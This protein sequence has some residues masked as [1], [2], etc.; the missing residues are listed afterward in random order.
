MTRCP[1]LIALRF[2]FMTAAFLFTFAP[3]SS[4]AWAGVSPYLAE[5]WQHIPAAATPSG[6]LYDR[7]LALSDIA[8]YDGQRGAPAIVREEWRQIHHELTRA[9]AAGPQAGGHSWP[10]LAEL[11]RCAGE[12]RAA[13]V[14]ALA[15][16]DVAYER[17]QPEA[18]VSPA[19]VTAES[20]ESHR[21]FAFTA[22]RDRTY[23]GDDV[24]FRLERRSLV[25]DPA[26]RTAND[27]AP[28][29]LPWTRLEADFGDGHGFQPLVIEADHHV[30]YER[31]GDV[32]LTLRAYAEDGTM[33]EARSIFHVESLG[34]PTPDDTLHITA[35]MDHLGQ[36]GTGQAYV[37]LSDSHTELT[38][39]AIVVEGFD[40]DNSMDWDE[41]Y[42][43]LNRESLLETLR[44]DGFD[45]VVL[46]F[47]DGVDYLQRNAYVVVELLQEIEDLTGGASVVLAGASMG[48]LLGRYALTY[49]EDQSIPHQVRTFISFDSPQNGAAIPLGIQYWLAFF[50]DDSAEAAALLAALNKPA[51]R[52]MLI[53]HYTD[54]PGATGQR[55]PL[56]TQF[57]SQLT[58]IGDHPVGPRTVAIANGS[59][60]GMNQ[61]F[62]AG[63]QIIQWTYRSFI[64]DIDGNVWAVPNGNSH[65]I[66]Q[67]LLDVIF[68]PEERQDVV[69]SGTSPWDS[70]PGG[71]RNSMEQM[72]AVTAPYGDIIALHPNH[73]FIPTVSALALDTTN[74]FYDIAGDPDLLSHTWFDAVYYPA[75]NQDH[76]EIT[77][78]NVVW[79]LEEIE[80]NPASVSPAVAARLGN[81]AVYPQPVLGTATV[82]FEQALEGPARFD[83]FDSGGRLR[84]T[85]DLGHLGAG[86]HEVSWKP[87]STI[88]SGMYFLRRTGVR[89]AATTR[90]V[91][92]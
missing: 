61:G 76:V 24:T 11:D 57:L 70:A 74:P 64:V 18:T 1:V 68:L 15:L 58:S 23:R 85:L 28:A 87:S 4:V 12:L 54:P 69:V 75:A 33:Q 21:A 84:E 90:V 44:A 5:T 39:P 16:L 47:S 26:A 81:L 32:T 65:I 49:M 82:R 80:S 50:E 8:R 83:L 22:L 67:G 46:N 62:N 48:G 3:V 89:H 78:E 53:Y 35:S 63:D 60:F 6:I 79:L 86:T 25:V 45:A 2:A 31:T 37:Y 66:F 71:F 36:F 91:V 19:T 14:T 27:L 34:T 88:A 17:V 43:L 73:C 51:S 56:R 55:D 9:A 7:V 13:G 30:R 10:G 41:L 52:Q 77:P 20:I 40:L 42:A 59:A 38:N 92:K 29:R 72:D